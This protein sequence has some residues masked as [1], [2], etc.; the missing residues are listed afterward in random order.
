MPEFDLTRRQFIA[1]LGAVVIS[2]KT[3]LPNSAVLT[4]TS[5][6]GGP[7][8]FMMVR[9]LKLR[10]SNFEIGRSLAKLAKSRH[11][12][13]L[14]KP[15]RAI[16]SSRKEWLEKQYPALAE[17]ARGVSREFGIA[18]GKS[19]EDPISLSYNGIQSPG[20]S[21]VYYPATHATSGHA[22]LSRNYDFTTQTLAEMTGRTGNASDRPFTADPYVIECRPDK[23]IPS[24]YLCS[25]DLLVGCIDGMNSEG[26]CVALLADDTSSSRAPS[27]TSK[28]GMGEIE[29]TRFLLDSCR[30]VDEAIAAAARASYYY[31][32]IPCHYLVGDASGRS[33]VLEWT[34]PAGKLKVVEGQRKCQVVTNHLLSSYPDQTKHPVESHPAGSFNRYGR[35]AKA[36]DSEAKFTP[37]EMKEING[38]VMPRRRPGEPKQRRPGRTLWHSLYDL[39]ALTLDVSFYLGEDDAK[40]MG[41]NR[42]A[43]HRFK[44]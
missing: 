35:L 41:Q 25:Y 30:N 31:T 36:L 8:D 32:F 3:F 43:Y 6:C 1:G 40:P 19:D 5:V 24:L 9:H 44:L 14:D 23:G 13:R 27:P 20:C 42:T 4:E 26:L 7:N 22:T 16:A 38:G 11:K 37:T 15:G 2:P 12:S 29:I 39:E 10:G 18:W 17:R 28:P 33:V 21:V 34:I